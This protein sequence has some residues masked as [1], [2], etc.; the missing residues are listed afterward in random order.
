VFL[1]GH[2][3]GGNVAI[4]AGH[5]ARVSGVIAQGAHSHLEKHKRLHELTPG[6]LSEDYIDDL[7]TIDVEEEARSLQKPCLIIHGND[8][9]RV[10]YHEARQLFGWL[11][12]GEW[13]E[14][15]GADHWFRDKRD[16]LVETVLNWIDSH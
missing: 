15:D 11:P 8:D 4:I 2:G 12:Q 5:D 1:F 16:E 9:L 10:T 14:V 6:V 3:L 13:Q 7:R